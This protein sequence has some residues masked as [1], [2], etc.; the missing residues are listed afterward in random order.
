[1]LNSKSRF[2][3]LLFLTLAMILMLGFI[4]SA[5]DVTLGE[6]ME[7][8]FSGEPVVYS[9]DAS[10]GQL[11]IA[12][13]QSDDIDSQVSIEQDGKEL[14]SD[15]DGGGWPNALLSYV[16]QEDG[17]FNILAKDSSYTPGEGAFTITIDVLD[18]VV[19][20]MDEAVNLEVDA[21]GSQ[22][23][24][25]VFKA[26]AG[27]VVNVLAGSAGEEDV[28]VTLYGVDAQVIETD[29][30]DGPG[31]NAL[32]RRVVLHD[33]GL[34]LVKVNQSYD[35]PLL[36]NVN[37]TVESTEQL[38]LSSEAQD[39]VLGD[40]EGF[41]GTEVYTLDVEAGKTYRFIVTIEPM[42][43]EEA[44][45]NMELLNTSFFFDPEL[46]VQHSTGVTWDFLA[47]ATN[48]ITVDVHPT[49]FGTD[50]SSIHYTIALE[51]IE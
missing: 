5:Q 29:D 37:V 23:V 31:D 8:Q 41:Y 4:V 35:D 25:T 32:L 7:G 40:A 15:D 45:I 1:M 46:D 22:A 42:P 44:G 47:H 48:T 43:D 27:D 11:I 50:I 18:P 20:S 17:S 12:A 21:E 33:D 28:E 6:A 14:A 3:V 24:Y 49:F 36:E 19:A 13:M 10:A 39:L 38:F 16:V 51:V 30:D 9:I 2:L 34:Y 26:A